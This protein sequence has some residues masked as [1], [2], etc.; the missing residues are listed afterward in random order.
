MEAYSQ[1]KDTPL[2]WSL[3]S[4]NK[5]RADKYILRLVYFYS[6]Y[7]IRCYLILTHKLECYLQFLKT[8]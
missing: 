3:L 6:Y 7:A 8:K 4:W 2:F 1:P 5:L